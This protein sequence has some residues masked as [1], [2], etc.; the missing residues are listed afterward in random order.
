MPRP[1]STRRSVFTPFSGGSTTSTGTHRQLFITPLN[2]PER[3]CKPFPHSGL[4]RS[5]GMNTPLNAPRVVRPNSA[6]GWAEPLPRP[7]NGIQ[8]D[9]FRSLGPRP[10]SLVPRPI[11]RGQAPAGHRRRLGP[12]SCAPLSCELH[13]RAAGDGGRTPAPRPP[14]PA[15]RLG[16]SGWPHGPQQSPVHAL[17]GPSPTRDQ[18]PNPAAAGWTG[19]HD[20]ADP[21][22]IRQGTGSHRSGLWTVQGRFPRRLGTQPGT[23]A[24]RTGKETGRW[25]RGSLS[26]PRPGARR[27]GA[28]A[29]KSSR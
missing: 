19:P 20:G 10:S 16:A 9:A 15:P 24:P 7:R 1:S 23:L 11:P 13:R 26:Q 28:A 27:R 6:A 21:L 3:Y 29:R 25:K 8:S 12:L 5:W 17:R 14:G 22:R 18:P 2:T 4:D